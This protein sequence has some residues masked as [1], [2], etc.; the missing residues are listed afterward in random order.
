MGIR[1]ITPS[2]I[3]P[4]TLAEL[5]AQVR[6]DSSDEDALLQGAIAAA[7]AKAENYT[8][9]VIMRRTLEQTLD[10]F[11]AAEFLVERT[12]AWNTGCNAECPIVIE[13]IQY[14]DPDGVTQ[15]LSPSDYTLDTSVWPGWVLPGVDAEWPDTEPSA[16]AVTVTLTIGYADEADV[17]FDIRAWMLLTAAFLWTHREA[18]D[19]TGKMIDI[20]SRFVDS[21]LDPYRVPSV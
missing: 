19:L 15:T 11:P 3:E 18:F 9:T 1:V 21:L 4:I 5:K 14:V 16:N 13:S 12:A 6:Y 17:P 20:P 7:R 2:T 8:G 10:E